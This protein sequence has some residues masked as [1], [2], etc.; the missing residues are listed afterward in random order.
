MKTK[1]FLVDADY[2]PYAYGDRLDIEAI[3]D[4]DSWLLGLQEKLGEGIYI[5]FLSGR[6]NFRREVATLKEYKANRK[7]K[8][9]PKYY[10]DIKNH[11][12]NAYDTIVV[13][14]AEADDGIALYANKYKD[15]YEVWIV[16]DDKDFG[17]ITCRQYKHSKNEYLDV[18]HEIVTRQRAKMDPLSGMIEYQYYKDYHGDFKLYQQ[19]LVGDSA[20]N[21]PGVQGIGANNKIFK[22]EFV[23]GITIAEARRL[24]WREYQRAYKH[25]SV[26]IY[27]EQY[28]LLRLIRNN[29]SVLDETQQI[30][31]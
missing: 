25:Q 29:N 5:H 7:G 31:Q 20:D 18:K 14:G 22:D 1:L 30:R 12:I 4:T 24:L 9:K 17:Q 21:I 15:K 2:A 16:S 11:I 23:N 26:A 3:V 28:M 8:E 10:T 6:G 27:L 13:N 19:M